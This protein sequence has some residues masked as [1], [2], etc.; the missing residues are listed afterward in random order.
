MN[1]NSYSTVKLSAGTGRGLLVI[2]LVSYWNESQGFKKQSQSTLEADQS[3]LV[4][5]GGECVFSKFFYSLWSHSA[6]LFFSFLFNPKKS[7]ALSL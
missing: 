2:A 4:C 6:F 7:A 5:G 3:F 1:Q